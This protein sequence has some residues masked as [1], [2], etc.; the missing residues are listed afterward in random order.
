MVIYLSMLFS[1]NYNS[2]AFVTKNKQIYIK[3][4]KS[5][6]GSQNMGEM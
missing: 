3:I 4:M 2:Y 6:P 1:I 5:Q